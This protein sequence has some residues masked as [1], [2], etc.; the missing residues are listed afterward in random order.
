M[1]HPQNQA[2][3]AALSYWASALHLAFLPVFVVVTQL[4]FEDRGSW[5][6]IVFGLLSVTATV[7]TV[8]RARSSLFR[9]RA[10]GVGLIALSVLSSVSILM[11]GAAHLATGPDSIGA[12]ALSLLG[13][14][15]HAATGLW[16]WIREGTRG[17]TGV[18]T[19]PGLA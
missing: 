3:P 11:A 16:L 14:L 19:G 15:L 2:G 5:L 6:E 10:S 9:H 1:N 18:R 17:T 7:L 4:P 12:G 8:V 13:I